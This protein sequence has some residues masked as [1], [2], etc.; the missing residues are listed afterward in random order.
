M[1]VSCVPFPSLQLFDCRLGNGL[2]RK[3]PSQ[4][5]IGRRIMLGPTASYTAQDHIQRNSRKTTRNKQPLKI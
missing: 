5:L 1:H 3:T 2:A 4:L